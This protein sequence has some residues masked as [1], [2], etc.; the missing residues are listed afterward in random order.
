MR[1]PKPSNGRIGLDRKLHQAKGFYGI[2]AI[3]TAL[4][5]ALNFTSIDPMKALFWSAVVNGLSLFRSCF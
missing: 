4:G 3:A 1:W 2:L 5:V